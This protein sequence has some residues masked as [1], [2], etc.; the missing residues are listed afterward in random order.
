MNLS[1]EF[2]QEVK[3]FFTKLHISMIDLMFLSAIITGLFFNIPK[4]TFKL[5][6]IDNKFL[7]TFYYSLYNVQV[8]F[9]FIFLLMFL[10]FISSSSQL[11]SFFYSKPYPDNWIRGYE[12]DTGFSTLLNIAK[13]YYHQVWIVLF[14]SLTISGTSNII[15]LFHSNGF[16]ASLIIYNSVVSAFRVLSAFFYTERPI[17]YFKETLDLTKHNDYTLINRH[18]NTLILKKH[19]LDT[20]IYL[21]IQLESNDFKKGTIIDASHTLSDIVYAFEHN[22]QLIDEVSYPV[23]SGPTPDKIPTINRKDSMSD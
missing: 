16:Q 6:P 2:Y 12:Q 22:A 17:S 18:K 3:K 4:N 1:I 23:K 14:F 10:L 5:F 19:S 13:K 11:S 21:L 20:P 15:K 9:C 8:L 7:L